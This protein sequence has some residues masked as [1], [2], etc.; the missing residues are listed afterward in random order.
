MNNY[1]LGSEVAVVL[2][3]GVASDGTPART[4]VLR[5]RAAARLAKAHPD[6]NLVV[7]G[8][9]RK[10]IGITSEA[11]AMKKILLAEGISADRIFLEDQSQDTIGNAV[12][13][14]ARYFANETPVA[15]RKLYVVTSPFHIGRALI[16]FRAV[17]PTHWE[18]VGYG[19][20]IAST[21]AARGANESGGVQW[22]KDFFSGIEPG[23]IA[24][25][26][27]RLLDC[28]PHYRSD[29]FAWLKPIAERQ[30]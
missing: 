26:V 4:T 1:N 19:S 8:D 28:R 12:L 18:V 14:A 17:V 22:M 20:R 11:E 7:S 6:V 13:V 10:H 25:A 30:S 21:D 5:V 15:T 2:G 23:D 27:E 9:G 29:E 3:S 24:A 16:A